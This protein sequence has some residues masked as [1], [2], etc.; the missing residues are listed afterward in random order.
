MKSDT[1]EGS[2]PLMD[3]EEHGEP[4]L[5]NLKLRRQRHGSLRDRLAAFHSRGTKVVGLAMLSILSV[6]AVLALVFIWKTSWGIYVSRHDCRLQSDGFFGDSKDTQL[7][8]LS[9][10]PRNITESDYLSKSSV[11]NRRP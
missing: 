1:Y 11:E 4:T 10:V 8:P 2:V 3:E 9:L 5:N 6:L 7:I